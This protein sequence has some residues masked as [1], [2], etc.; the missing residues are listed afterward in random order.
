MVTFIWPGTFFPL[1]RDCVGGGRLRPSL[2]ERVRVRGF[3]QHLG[4]L[5]RR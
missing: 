4:T 3:F 5:T 2:W 1:S